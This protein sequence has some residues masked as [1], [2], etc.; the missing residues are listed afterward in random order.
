M[1]EASAAVSVKES[2]SPIR[3]DDGPE[4]PATGGTLLTVRLALSAV[5]AEASDTVTSI[6]KLPEGSLS[7]YKC[8][9]PKVSTPG[10]RF[11]IV[12]PSP[13][14]QFMTTVCESPSSGSTND[15]LRVAMLFSL[16]EA[17]R[18]RVKSDGGVLAL[19][20]GLTRIVTTTLLKFE[21][22]SD[23]TNVN[24]SVPWNPGSGT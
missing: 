16:I 21:N 4:M 22:P 2:G 10:S 7:R 15:P 24:V 5:V 3:P 6:E 8:P 12:V 17:L 13:G 19:P 9:A 18:S 1:G 11:K 14:P 23:G 20:T